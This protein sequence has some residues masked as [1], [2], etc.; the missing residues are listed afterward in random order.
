MYAALPCAPETPLPP[1]NCSP[2]ASAS[3]RLRSPPCTSSCACEHLSAP[4][5]RS[6][7]SGRLPP[8]HLERAAQPSSLP[9]RAPHPQSQSRSSKPSL[10]RPTASQISPPSGSSSQ[11]QFSG[12]VRTRRSKPAHTLLPLFDSSLVHSPGLHSSIGEQ[13]F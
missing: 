7:S 11:P 8:P 3:A 9:A 5:T 13:M 10:S 4:A 2:T 6:I 1:A 12:Q